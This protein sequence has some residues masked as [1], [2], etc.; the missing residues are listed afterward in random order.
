MKKRISIIVV[1]I[2][3]LCLHQLY[4]G[5]VDLDPN[6][7]SYLD[8]LVDPN[9]FDPDRINKLYDIEK[10]SK[11]ADEI[12]VDL[13]DYYLGAGGGECLSELI[14]K[15]GKRMIPILKDKRMRPVNCFP[16]YKSRC[17]SSIKQR[18]EKIDEFVKA[19][20]CGIVLCPDFNNCPK[21]EG[22]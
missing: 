14:T 16:V 10:L 21:M 15:R 9:T 3:T 13:T 12:Y 8:I 7:K 6:L 1:I 2:S 17:V 5:S 18:N 22:K 4:G 20:E 11:N 19:I